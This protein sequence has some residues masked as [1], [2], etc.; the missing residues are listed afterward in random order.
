VLAEQTGLWHV[1]PD[2]TEIERLGP[3]K[4]TSI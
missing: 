4:K 1:A 3:A 2:G